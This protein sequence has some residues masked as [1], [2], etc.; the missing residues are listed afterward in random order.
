[1]HKLV[2]INVFVNRDTQKRSQVVEG[3]ENRLVLQS[4]KLIYLQKKC[5]TDVTLVYLYE[6]K[7]VIHRQIHRH[8]IIVEIFE[9]LKNL[10][11]Y[12][13]DNCASFGAKQAPREG[14]GLLKPLPIN[15]P[16][17][18]CIRICL[19]VCELSSTVTPATYR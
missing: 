12:E 3:L 10:K 9:S 16:H 14:V 17:Y 13:V 8:N 6:E 15:L 11:V 4:P 2:S 19:Q 7:G 5:A 1:M 18:K